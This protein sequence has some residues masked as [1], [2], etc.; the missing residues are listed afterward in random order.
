MKITLKGE[1][2]MLLEWMLV[3]MISSA[4]T[5]IHMHRILIKKAALRLINILKSQQAETTQT[6]GVVVC[7][8][9]LGLAG[10]LEKPQA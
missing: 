8:N 5:V 4:I 3:L 6:L 10:E 1:V 2:P 9:V 7:V